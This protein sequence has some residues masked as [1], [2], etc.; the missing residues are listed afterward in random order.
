MLK[1]LLLEEVELTVQVRQTVCLIL[2]VLD[3]SFQLADLFDQLQ[4]IVSFVLIID[5]ALPQC[6]LLDLDLLVQQ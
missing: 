4:N 5:A 2:R 1:E 3:H 6:R